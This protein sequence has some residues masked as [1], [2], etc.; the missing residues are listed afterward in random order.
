MS[1]AED[2][3]GGW[4]SPFSGLFTS[5]SWRAVVVLVTGALL[6]PHRR[7]V[8]FS[9]WRDGSRTGKDFGPLPCS[10]QSEP[11]VGARGGEGSA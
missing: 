2:R 11:L 10:A 3:L 4:L 5:P 7:T 8:S 9:A 1:A 6:T